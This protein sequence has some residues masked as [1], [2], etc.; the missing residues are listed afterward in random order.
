VNE[1]KTPAEHPPIRMLFELDRADDPF[2]YDDLMRCRK[3]TRRANRLRLLAHEGVVAQLHL[4]NAGAAPRLDA[5]APVVGAPS[6]VAPE[7]EMALAS[8]VFG[9]PIAEG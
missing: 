7:I 2:L 8:D 4:A 5:V 1:K 3:G 9:D 6:V